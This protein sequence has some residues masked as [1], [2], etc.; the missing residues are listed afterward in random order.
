[1]ADHPD[2]RLGDD[3]EP[4]LDF[5]GL[6]WASPPV[7]PIWSPAGPRRRCAAHPGNADTA[8]ATTTRT[9]DRPGTEQPVDAIQIIALALS[10]TG[11]ALSLWAARIAYRA[12]KRP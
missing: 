10:G 4:P 2:G 8:P 9:T 11:F 3:F 1:M 6:F 7:P 5:T 12:R